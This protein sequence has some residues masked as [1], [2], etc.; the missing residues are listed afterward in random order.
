MGLDV[1]DAQRRG[2]RLMH[3]CVARLGASA[4]AKLSGAVAAVCVSLVRVCPQTLFK[5]SKPAQIFK[6]I[7]V[8]RRTA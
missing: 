8:P 2:F 5:H 3:Y 7:R 6:G 4:I 1:Y